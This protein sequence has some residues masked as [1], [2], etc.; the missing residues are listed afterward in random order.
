M[1]AWQHGAVTSETPDPYERVE[2]EL[3]YLVRRAQGHARELAREVHPD[4]DV[5]SYS[6]LGRVDD[7]DGLRSTDLA[8]HFGVDK[9]VVSRQVAHLERLGLLRREDDPTDARARRLALTAEGR[10][11]LR[12]VRGER[13]RRFQDL[14]RSW[15]TDE[16]A[17]FA[18]DLAR[19]NALY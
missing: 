4:L 18:D 1:L 17:R 9:S 10:S 6:M 19:W 11:R 16:V 15:D 3:I 7:A 5:A 2:R 13:H 14:L 12:R 8:A